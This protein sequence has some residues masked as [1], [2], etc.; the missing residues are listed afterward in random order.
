MIESEV[1]F[2]LLSSDLQDSIAA[3]I[4]TIGEK[5]IEGQL[6]VDGHDYWVILEY[7]SSP[8]SQQPGPSP[9]DIVPL[10]APPA[11]AGGSKHHSENYIIAP[12]DAKILRFF[13]DGDPQFSMRVAHPGNIPRMHIRQIIQKYEEK[14]Q[15]VLE[16]MLFS[17]DTDDLPTRGELVDLFDT[18]FKAIY[19]DVVADTPVGTGVQSLQHE[20]GHLQNAWGY[21]VLDADY[22]QDSASNF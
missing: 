2:P 15:T 1:T 3:M 22:S 18:F 21:Q 13:K 11:A 6:T 4:A 9:D 19:D 14:L 7:G 20:L 17:D 10:N 12:K 5:P 16:D 8:A